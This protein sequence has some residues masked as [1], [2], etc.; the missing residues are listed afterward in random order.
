MKSVLATNTSSEDKTYTQLIFSTSP[1]RPH[2]LFLPI[3]EEAAWWPGQIW[4]V[5]RLSAL[6]RGPVGDWP[7]FKTTLFSCLNWL[8]IFKGAATN[9]GCE[10]LILFTPV[11]AQ[12]DLSRC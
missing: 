7:N 11:A 3:V 9:F 12:V 2:D 5:S 4:V 10:E 6:E 8:N 1:I